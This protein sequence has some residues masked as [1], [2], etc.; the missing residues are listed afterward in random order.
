MVLQWYSC[1]TIQRWFVQTARSLGR[2]CQLLLGWLS[3]VCDHA[4]SWVTHNH[5][6]CPDCQQPLCM[7]HR[8]LS[9]SLT[10]L[11]YYPAWCHIVAVCM[12]QKRWVS[13]CLCSTAHSA[14]V[15]RASQLSTRCCLQRSLKACMVLADELLELL[16]RE[17]KLGIS[18]KDADPYIDA[19]LKAG[20][21]STPD[22]IATEVG[23][24]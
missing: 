3:C 14:C 5:M 20:A 23:H 2:A 10:R 7:Y 12:E 9:C 6:D 16:E 19:Y 1:I 13:M 11:M 4:Q 15:A 17:K 22:H 18:S 8:R 24:H 21:A